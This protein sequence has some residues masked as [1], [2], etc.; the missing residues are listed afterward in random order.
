[1]IPK[2]KQARKQRKRLYNLPLH[3]KHGLLAV[4]LSKPLRAKFKR[5]ALEVKKGDKVKLIKGTDKGVEGQ[6][7]KVDVSETKIYVDK[8]V[9]KKRDGT[10]VLRAIRP[11][12]LMIMDIDI[13][14]KRR[15]DVLARKVGQGFV[16]QEAKKEEDRMKREEAERKAKE[17]ERKREEE[18]KKAKE[19]AK[20]EAKAEEAGEEVKKAKVSE[21]GIDEKT[22]KEWIAEK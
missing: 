18:A 19:E 16:E 15:Q 13:R 17:E 6:V 8:L 4:T 2:T 20:A 22:K 7:M 10:E 21:K 12:N 5:R 9:L 14:D 1:M 11:A 3:K